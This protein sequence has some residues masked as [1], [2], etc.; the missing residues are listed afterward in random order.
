MILTWRLV[1]TLYAL[2]N[3][4]A[5]V[6]SL[7]VIMK[8][9]RSLQNYLG[10]Y[11]AHPAVMGL[12]ACFLVLFSHTL[13]T[14]CWCLIELHW[15]MSL[16]WCYWF[17]EQSDNNL[18][19]GKSQQPQRLRFGRDSFH[20][21]TSAIWRCLQKVRY[22]FTENLFLWTLHVFFTGVHLHHSHWFSCCKTLELYYMWKLHKQVSF[23]EGR[24]VRVLRNN[25]LLEFFGPYVLQP[26]DK[27]ETTRGTTNHHNG[28]C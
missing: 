12:P 15:Y 21:D 19:S 7:A 6:S 3:H 26:R 2:S 27:Q 5:S 18:L 13:S 4:S 1:L 28:T 17:T 14:F 11:E 10:I 24:Y 25:T 22:L 9:Y 8:C 16:D 20:G 23:L